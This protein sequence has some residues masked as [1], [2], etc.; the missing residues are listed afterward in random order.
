MEIIP[1]WHP[2]FVHFTLGL[3]SLSVALYVISV[4]LKS[5]ELKNQ[6]QIVARWNLWL[7]TAITL[8]TVLA[9]WY[10]YNTVAHDEPSHLAM[11]EHRNWA[12]VTTATFLLLTAWSIWQHSKARAINPL[13]IL[14]LVAAAVLLTSTAWHGGELVY[15]HGLG[16][17]SLPDTAAESEHGHVHEHGA[18]MDATQE[19]TPDSGRTEPSGH[20]DHHQHDH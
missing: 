10:A 20:D 8:A 15:R 1:N 5:P 13:F 6:W 3:L 11:T 18:S 14:G 16:V 2:I 17:M 4:F 9:G 7:G 12:L 19:N